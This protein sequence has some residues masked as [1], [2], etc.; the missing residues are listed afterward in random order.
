MA[1]VQ[2]LESFGPR[3]FA[4]ME[5]FFEQLW[6]LLRMGRFDGFFANWW[7][8]ALLLALGGFLMDQA[9]YYAR[10][11]GSSL[12]V[13]LWQGAKTLYRKLRGRAP[14]EP[15]D[16]AAAPEAL[17]DETIAVQDGFSGPAQPQQEPARADWRCKLHAVWRHAVSAFRHVQTLLP[18]AAAALW[19][20]RADASSDQPADGYDAQEYDAYDDA[21][22]YGYEDDAWAQDD[23]EGYDAQDYGYEDDARAQDDAEDYD[24]RDYGYEPGCAQA[25]DAAQDLGYESEAADAYDAPAVDGVD[26]YGAQDGRYEF[27]NADADGGAQDRGYAAG[28]QDLGYESETADAYDAPAADGADAFGYE[29]ET[30]DA[31][32]TQDGNDRTD[33]GQD[34]PVWAAAP[35]EDPAN[36][37]DAGSGRPAANALDA[38]CE[39]DRTGAADGRYDNSAGGAEN[40]AYEAA[41][42]YP[43]RSDPLAD[44]PTRRAHPGQAQREAS[45]PAV[46][47]Q[48][49][50]GEAYPEALRVTVELPEYLPKQKKEKDEGYV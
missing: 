12:L 49:P 24:T 11:G 40:A 20:R 32:D 4:W 48:A 31:Y 26:S 29:S 14:D 15:E 44:P 22:D 39:K 47:R 41:D 17:Y 45:Q 1:F 18:G 37:P 23:A 13:R 10:Y 25:E 16:P 28:A 7:K 50:Q 8:I 43:T 34:R 5:G 42:F 33:G 6:N 36:A 21:Q 2:W 19:P 35:G 9:L 46:T 30:A 38:A 3:M 27:R